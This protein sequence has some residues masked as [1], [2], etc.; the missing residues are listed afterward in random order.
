MEEL[1]RKILINERITSLVNN[2]IYLLKAPDNTVAPYIEYEILNE[3]GSLYAENE[4]LATNYTVQ[5]DIFTKGSY[6]AIVKAIKNVMKENEFMKEFGGSRY[7]EDSKL[8]H[9]ILRFNYESEE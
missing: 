7:E 9:Y 4:E 3:S 6:T 1:L 2:K 5:I 8:F